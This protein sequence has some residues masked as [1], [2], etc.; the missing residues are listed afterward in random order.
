MRLY[1]LARELAVPIR[2]L[3]QEASDAGIGVASHMSS[4]DG[5]EAEILRDKIGTNGDAVATA[6]AELP[7][8]PEVA[9]QITPMRGE[10]GV[11][12]NGVPF[13][14]GAAEFYDG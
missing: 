3:L 6:V 5:E 14:P 8:E 1:H 2:T 7:A 9:D 11:A 10:F 12:I 4:I 13:D